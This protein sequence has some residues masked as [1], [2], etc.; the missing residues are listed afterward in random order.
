MSRGSQEWVVRGRDFEKI[1]KDEWR[2]IED[3]NLSFE[4]FIP[5]VNGKRGRADILIRDDEGWFSMIEIKAS[6][7]DIMADYRIRPNLLRHV[8]QVMSYVEF[9]YNEGIDI[10]PALV[11]PR[12]PKSIERRRIIESLL[13]EKWIQ[14]VWAE[15]RTDK[16]PSRAR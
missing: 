14:V 13:D 15:E 8:R 16:R 9:Y 5:L 1:E 2:H 4:S 6:D 3:D 10:S 7:W 12:A 11:Y